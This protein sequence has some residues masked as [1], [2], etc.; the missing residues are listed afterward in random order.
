MGRTR[1]YLL[2]I[3]LGVTECR[4]ILYDAPLRDLAMRYKEYPLQTP[5]G[6]T[7]VPVDTE[8]RPLCPSM[9]WLDM[10]AQERAGQILWDFSDMAIFAHT[11][12]HQCLPH[13]PEDPLTPGK[14]VGDLGK[15]IQAADADG[16]STGKADRQLRNRSLDD[17]PVRCYTL[18]GERYSMDI[19]G[20]TKDSVFSVEEQPADSV[21][22]WLSE[23]PKTL[24]QYPFRF[25]FQVRYALCGWTVA[26]T[27]FVRN[28]DKKELPFGIGGH[29]GFR[30]PL[31][32]RT[33]FKDYEL[34]FSQPCQPDRVGFT[35]ACF[36]NGHDTCYPL[37]NGTTIRLRHDLF[38]NDANVLKN[39]ARRVTLCSAKTNRSVTVPYPQMPYLGIWYMPYTDVPYV[40]IE[41]WASL[42][43]RQDVVEELSCESNLIILRRVQN[44][45]TL[46][47]LRSRRNEYPISVKCG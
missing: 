39:M 47:A 24:C 43:S 5:Q 16:L 38:D 33:A 31:A 14:P 40:C 6:I 15:D 35:E 37:E 1:H 19:H 46:G 29:P 45:K 22:L 18:Y 21:T 42:P 7:L 2:S 36:L 17:H 8:R 44:T 41:P 20:F 12:K 30:V 26:V 34:R 25:S 11:G 13:T 4:G 9:T 10:R 23:T 32:E 27:Y 28:E 3:A